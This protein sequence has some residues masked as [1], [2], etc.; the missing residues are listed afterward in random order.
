L[1]GL[2]VV[3]DVLRVQGFPFL[4]GHV[5]FGESRVGVDHL[6]FS[7]ADDAQ[8][9]RLF[10]VGGFFGVDRIEVV[11]RAERAGDCDTP[12]LGTGFS[13]HQVWLKRLEGRRGTLSI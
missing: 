3:F 5:D 8:R 12:G 2:H 13:G 10:E 6:T 4:V 1:F 7:T 11:A 9:N